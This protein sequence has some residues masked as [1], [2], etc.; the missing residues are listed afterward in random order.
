MNKLQLTEATGNAIRVAIEA[1]ATAKRAVIEASEAVNVSDSRVNDACEIAFKASQAGITGEAIAKV[2]GVTPMTVSRYI[3]GGKLMMQTEGKIT[4]SK[5]VSDMGNGYLTVGA[6]KECENVSQYNKAVAEGKKAKAGKAGKA[7]KRSPLEIAQSHVEAIGK[8]VKAGKISL[9]E[10]TTLW[11]DMVSS[12]D[13]EA[14]APVM[15][16]AEI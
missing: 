3:A 4:G 6:V 10:I 13:I 8:A 11:V 16:D 9:E 5:A 2:A 12:L 14:E 1:Q 7:D 15:E